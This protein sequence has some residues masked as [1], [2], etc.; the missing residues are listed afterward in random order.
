MSAPVLPN[1]DYMMGHVE[2]PL[3]ASWHNSLPTHPGRELQRVLRKVRSP[4][5]GADRPCGMPLR[6]GHASDDVSCSIDI[7]VEQ[8]VYLVTVHR[9]PP[10]ACDASQCCSRWR[11]R[12]K[13]DMTVPSGTSAIA[14]MS[15][16]DNP[17]SSRKIMASRKIG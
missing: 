15:L 1:M 8:V 4:G 9:R 6:D 12:A 14:A 10:C 16:Y 13:R 17:S 5:G 11:A 7:C 2:T 3:R